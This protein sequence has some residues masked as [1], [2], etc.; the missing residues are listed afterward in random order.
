MNINTIFYEA[1]ANFS[2]VWECNNCGPPNF[3]SSLLDSIAG[4]YHVNPFSPLESV[5]ADNS[6]FGTPEHTSSTTFGT[7]SKSHR[8]GNR[9]LSVQIIDFQSIIAKNLHFVQ[10]ALEQILT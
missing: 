5:S 8:A 3:S 2:C 9:T 10:M 4:I 6:I 1:L 7:E